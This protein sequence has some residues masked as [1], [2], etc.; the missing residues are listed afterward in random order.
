VSDAQRAVID[1]AK[2]LASRNEIVLGRGRA[3]T[4]N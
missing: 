4:K 2:D 1:L 3:A